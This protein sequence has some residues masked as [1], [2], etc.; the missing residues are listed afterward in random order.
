MNQPFTKTLEC[1]EEEFTI[2]D[3][4]KTIMNNKEESE[5]E[6]EC[7]YPM[8]TP[9]RIS[10]LTGTCLVTSEINLVVL[11]RYLELNKHITYINYGDVVSKGI[12]ITPKSLKKKKKKKVFY[13]QIT[14]IIKQGAD[15]YNNIKLFANGAVSMTG[16]QSLEE[17]EISIN[18]ILDSIKN[19]KGKILYNI[20]DSFY[21]TNIK[22]ES[23][24]EVMV[25]CEGC[26]EKFT[27]HTM[28]LS[29]ECG[30]YICNECSKDHDQCPNKE[31]NATFILPALTNE[32]AKVKKFNIVLIN[33]DYKANFRINQKKLHPLI[34]NKYQIFSTF[35]P[36]I[37]PGVKSMY[38]WNKAYTDK[39]VQGKCYCIAK[40]N[41]KGTGNG[42]GDCKKVTTAVFQSG[43]VLIT[44]GRSMEQIEDGYNFINT[45]LK[46]EFAQIRKKKAKFLDD[47]SLL[48]KPTPPKEDS[49]KIK[50]KRSLI[51]DYPSLEIIKQ[52]ENMKVLNTQLSLLNS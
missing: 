37:Y 45:I 31:C 14:I 2:S 30:H 1:S 42:D 51:I 28:K 27:Y 6:D 12:N 43:S 22:K 32:E 44:G 10:T 24:E 23:D 21:N 39:P 52:L 5:D 34:V 9:L 11:A 38:F 19:L 29:N 8:P 13:N 35:E 17:G 7:E 50:L 40:C 49:K 33:S 48:Q 18:I 4:I 3:Y 26:K 47:Q 36:T 41:G 25:D 46:N 16:L 20:T 15:R